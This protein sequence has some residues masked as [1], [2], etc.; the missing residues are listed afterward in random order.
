M[1]YGTC[2]Y[3]KIK[4]LFFDFLDFR[5][6]SKISKVFWHFGCFCKRNCNFEYWMSAVTCP[7]ALHPRRR[8]PKAR[9]LLHCSAWSLAIQKHRCYLHGERKWERHRAGLRKRALKVNI[10]TN[11][12]LQNI[13]NVQTLQNI[14]KLQ[15]MNYRTYWIIFHY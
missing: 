12:K 11:A 14:Q 8:R 2:T 6:F 13:Q 9:S 15:N 10:W 7:L 5:T 1:N 3:Y 4:S